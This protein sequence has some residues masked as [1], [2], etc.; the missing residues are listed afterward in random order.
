MGVSVKK[1]EIAARK[2][3]ARNNRTIEGYCQASLAVT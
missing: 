1:M 2:K 3:R